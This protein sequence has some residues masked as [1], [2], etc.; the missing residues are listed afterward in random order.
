MLY[1]SLDQAPKRLRAEFNHTPP[2]EQFSAWRACLQFRIERPEEPSSHNF[3][4]RKTETR[5]GLKKKQ[6]TYNLTSQEKVG[7]RK[8]KSPGAGEMAWCLRPPAAPAE[9]SGWLP[10]AHVVVLKQR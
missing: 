10:R 4:G 2:P 5:E 6:L 8:N 7:K 3:R 9:D 1:S